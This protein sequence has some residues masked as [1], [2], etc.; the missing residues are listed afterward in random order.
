MLIYLNVTCLTVFFFIKQWCDLQ[1]HTKINY[2]R[3]NGHATESNSQR[4]Y[5]CETLFTK[6]MIALIHIA[7]INWY[8]L[9]KGKHVIEKA[10]ALKI[11]LKFGKSF[12]LK[13][14][15]VLNRTSLK[16]WDLYQYAISQ[17]TKYSGL[18][19]KHSQNNP[20]SFFFIILKKVFS[21][22]LE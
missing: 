6:I 22:F 7:K 12:H 13:S 21:T 2:L 8:I 1:M 5:A 3:C 10:L 4:N 16:Q 20:I 14:I 18:W 19:I 11:T 17:T 15:S 9:L